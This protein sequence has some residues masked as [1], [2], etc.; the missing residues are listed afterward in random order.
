MQRVLRATRHA[1]DAEDSLLSQI[2]EEAPR[3]EP[4]ARRLRAEY[5]ELERVVESL[6]AQLE[7][8]SE[9]KNEV[10]DVRGKVRRMIS[11]LRLVEAKEAELLYEA[12][13]VDI[14][15]GD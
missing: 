2:A 11:E 6:C 12:F 14:G 8:L 10:E 3:L 5:S 1:A 4:R 15:N 7:T 13:L 9:T